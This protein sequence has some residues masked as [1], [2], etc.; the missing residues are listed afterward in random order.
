MGKQIL[1]GRFAGDAYY[2]IPDIYARHQINGTVWQDWICMRMV[3]LD[4]PLKKSQTAIDFSFLNFSL[5]F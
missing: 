5:N 2:S 1:L 3:P 4:R